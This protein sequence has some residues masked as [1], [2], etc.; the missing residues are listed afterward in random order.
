MPLSFLFLLFLLDRCCRRRQRSFSDGDI[1]GDYKYLLDDQVIMAL[2]LCAPVS[3]HHEKDT[4]SPASTSLKQNEVSTSLTQNKESEVADP[5]KVASVEAPSSSRSPA[6]EKHDENVMEVGNDNDLPKRVRSV[7]DTQESRGTYERDSKYQSQIPTVSEGHMNDFFGIKSFGSK[8]PGSSVLVPPLA[9]A[10]APKVLPPASSIGGGSS[11]VS[12]QEAPNQTKSTISSDPQE[13]VDGIMPKTEVDVPRSTA[14]RVALTPPS[15]SWTW[16]ALPVKSK[17]KSSTDAVTED[18]LKDLEAGVP[19]ISEDVHSDVSGGNITDAIEH[20]EVS[21]VCVSSCVPVSEPEVNANNESHNVHLSTDAGA[22]V[23]N[24]HYTDSAAACLNSCSEDVKSV[25]VDVCPSTLNSK[26][27]NSKQPMTGSANT[28]DGVMGEPKL[29]NVQEDTPVVVQTAGAGVSMLGA[30]RSHSDSLLASNVFRTESGN[31]DQVC[32]VENIISNAVQS[33]L[34]GFE[35]GEA[36]GDGDT[37]QELDTLSLH[38]IPLDQISPEPAGGDFYDSDTESYLSL[39]LDDG[40]TAKIPPRSKFGKYRYRRVLVPSQEQL[41]SLDLQDGENEISFVLQRQ[42]SNG[43][44]VS[45]PPLLRNQLFVWPH[46]A[47]IV[48]ID[49]EGVITAINKGGKGWGMGG[50]LSAPRTAVHNGVA[51]LLTNIHN[52]G[53]RILYIA[54]STST[55]LSTKEHL[56]KVGAGSDINLPPGPVFQSPDSLIKA[57]GAART[58]LFKAAALRYF[59][60]H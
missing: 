38:D 26:E 36:D 18:R 57:F 47:K 4:D 53:Y 59:S 13:A 25:T 6:S 43:A 10:L 34:G 37:D 2:S 49:I 23:N 42:E 28:D 35:E 50:F 41:L 27:S 11:T 56:A 45:A 7:S 24:S 15:W 5:S 32:K 55:A 54:Q 52:N 40:D 48:I 60:L 3:F 46:D 58:D 1:D 8:S 39:S 17:T 31:V 44:Y 19:V 9:V 21:P 14:I 16:G 51:K 22:E 33:S 30:Q 12:C 20:R 29:G